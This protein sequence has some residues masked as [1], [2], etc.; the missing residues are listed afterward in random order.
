MRFDEE[1]TALVQR[2][3]ELVKAIKSHLKD[4]KVF[5]IGETHIDVYIVGQTEGGYAGLKT[6]VVET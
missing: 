6:R 3:Q 5:R 4:V 1:E 2:F